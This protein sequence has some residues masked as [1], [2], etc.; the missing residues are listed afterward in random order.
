MMNSNNQRGNGNGRQNNSGNQERNSNSNHS[1]PSKAIIKIKR[2]KESKRTITAELQDDNGNKVKKL[3]P[4]YSDGD[5]KECIIYLA[6]RLE[7]FDN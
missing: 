6:S 2:A 3:V 7:Y 4:C 5:P 1:K